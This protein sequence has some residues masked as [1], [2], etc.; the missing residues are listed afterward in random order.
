MDDTY[1]SF[2]SGGYMEFISTS[3]FWLII[4]RFSFKVGVS[5]PESTPNSLLIIINFWTFWAPEIAF[6]FAAAIPSS[7]SLFNVLQAIACSTVVAL[8]PLGLI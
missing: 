4:L 7:I 6:L 1:H 5:S 8:D 3:Y 2:G